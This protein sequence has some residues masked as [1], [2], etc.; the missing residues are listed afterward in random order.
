MSPPSLLVYK[1][2][3]QVIFQDSSGDLLIPPG[4]RGEG[5]FVLI[6]NPRKQLHTLSTFQ[7]YIGTWERLGGEPWKQLSRAKGLQKR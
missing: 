4:K 1:P 6:L 7:T 5:F 2:D 3:E